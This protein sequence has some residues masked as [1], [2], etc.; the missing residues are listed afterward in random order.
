MQ[1]AADIHG[2]EIW[3]DCLVEAVGE[4]T[5]IELGREFALGHNARIGLAA[6]RQARVARQAHELERRC[7]DGIGQ[8]VASIDVAA[9]FH[10]QARYPGCWADPGFVRE[11][12]RDNPQARVRTTPRACII[13]P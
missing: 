9:F 13:R 5:A 3:A 11:F 2:G 6:A 4:E 12:L 7:V 8:P 10:W 1:A